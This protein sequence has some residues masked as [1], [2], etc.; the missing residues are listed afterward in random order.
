MAFLHLA[1][2]FILVITIT[3]MGCGPRAPQI[4]FANRVYSGALR[5][6]TNT[7]NP[8]RLA[9]AKKLIERDRASG[10]IGEQEYGFYCDIIDLAEA[11]RWKEAEQKAIRFRRDQLR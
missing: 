8:E 4:D 10:T 6:A 2:A 3:A 5:T 7:K 1:V 11:G 9:K